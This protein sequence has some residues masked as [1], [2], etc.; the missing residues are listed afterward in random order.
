MKQNVTNLKYSDL[1]SDVFVITPSQVDKITQMF[2]DA[3]AETMN[4]RPLTQKIRQI[5]NETLIKTLKNA[6][7]MGE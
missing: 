3:L 1:A 7:T 5:A 2:S 6:K 4:V